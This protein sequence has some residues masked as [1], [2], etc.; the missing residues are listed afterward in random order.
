MESFTVAWP[1]SET[2]VWMFLYDVSTQEPLSETNKKKGQGLF[3][4]HPKF[5]KFD[6]ILNCWMTRF[7]QYQNTKT[8]SSKKHMG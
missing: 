7:R 8:I 4:K 3:T 1:G 2:G 5:Q 6:E